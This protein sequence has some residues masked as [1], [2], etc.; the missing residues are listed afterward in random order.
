MRD[1]ALVPRHIIPAFTTAFPNAPVVQLDH[2]GHFPQEDDPDP[3]LAALQVF[4]R[5]SG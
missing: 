5:T 2:A 4:L 1:T 3:V